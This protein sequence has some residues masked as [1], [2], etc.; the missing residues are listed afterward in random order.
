MRKTCSIII[1]KSQAS[2]SSL[3]STFTS[4]SCRANKKQAELKT[5]Y[6]DMLI[7]HQGLKDQRAALESTKAVM[8]KGISIKEEKSEKKLQHKTKSGKQ[9]IT[10]TLPAENTINETYKRNSMDKAGTT[11]GEGRASN[12]TFSNDT[13][14]N[15]SMR[16]DLDIISKKVLLMDQ[17]IQTLASD[18]KAKSKEISECKLEIAEYRLHWDILQ[19]QVK[20]LSAQLNA[21]L[22]K[23]YQEV[24]AKIKKESGLSIDMYYFL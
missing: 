18:L 3:C 16:D 17:N 8:S 1:P 11:L 6:V 20:E 24:G 4:F 7:E 21:A 2:S 5:N 10:L 13:D 14:H 22:Y 19:A 12:G 9:A 15:A 23:I